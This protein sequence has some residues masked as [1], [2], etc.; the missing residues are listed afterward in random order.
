[1]SVSTIH[2]S[3]GLEWMDVHVPWFNQGLLPMAFREERD[4]NK[5]ERH[6]RGCGAFHAGG[7]CDKDCKRFFAEGDAHRGGT[8]EER[9]NDEERRLAHVAATRAKDRLT[10]VS[11]RTQYTIKGLE[12]LEPSEFEPQLAKLDA[13]VFEVL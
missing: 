4:G 11:V 2:R 13:E 8:P 12:K 6:V 1:M 3:K 10:F 9:H 7:T 5:A